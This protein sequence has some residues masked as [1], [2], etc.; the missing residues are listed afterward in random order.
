MGKTYNDEVEEAK[1]TEIDM[2]EAEAEEKAKEATEEA[3]TEE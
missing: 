3:T 1:T 2:T